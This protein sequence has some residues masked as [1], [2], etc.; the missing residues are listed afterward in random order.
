[1]NDIFSEVGAFLLY[2]L[3]GWGILLVGIGFII[4]LVVKNIKSTGGNVKKGFNFFGVVVLAVAIGFV[5][6][7]I[8]HLA[9][10]IDP[11][12]EVKEDVEFEKQLD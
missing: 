11:N 7:F 9:I 1:M 10:D 3:A 12:R 2:W 4:W 5:F 8:T 6:Y